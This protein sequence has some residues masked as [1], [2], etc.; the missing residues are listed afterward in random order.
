[1]AE[2]MDK[3]GIVMSKALAVC[4]TV[5]DF[6]ALLKSYPKPM[7]VEANFG[8]ID[9]LGNGAYFETNNS[10][11]IRYDLK[12]APDGVLIRTN[13]SYSGRADEG[14]GYIR[15]ENARH[16]FA[17]HIAAGDFTP[18][19]LTEE[20]SRS[21]YHSLLGE[22]F[23]K[24]D[25]EW[26]I[27]QDFIPRYTSTATCAIE[28]VLQGENPAE[29]TMWIGLGFPPCSE[30]RAVWL[31]DGGLP[32]ELR[33]IGPKGHSPLCDTVVARKHEVFPIVRG[34]GKHYINFRK[35]YN[36]E[37]TGYCQRLVPQNLETYRKAYQTLEQRRK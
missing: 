25:V 31:R 23:A 3:E 21:Y 26:V 14:S 11:Y 6:E 5:D 22:D 1:P 17:P 10:E 27:D 29:T 28:G 12:D 7:G 8:A 19:V 16:L 20:I 24:K 30:I 32:E 15:H 2:E 9:A 13:Y 35:L 37:G 36:P 4:R 33:G 34:N 18:A